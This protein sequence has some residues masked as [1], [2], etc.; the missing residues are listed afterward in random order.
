M[1]LKRT[2]YYSDT[3]TSDSFSF[4]VV[5]QFS[6]SHCMIAIFLSFAQ[7]KWSILDTSENKLTHTFLLPWHYSL[8]IA[9][10][11]DSSLESK[12][13]MKLLG[14]FSGTDIHNHSSKYGPDGTY[15]RATRSKQASKNIFLKK[16]DLLIF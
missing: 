6:S 5:S 4:Y 2:Q 12:H 9:E 16:I 3:H 10:N 7:M 14:F 13:Q 15:P 1:L 8:A 11:C